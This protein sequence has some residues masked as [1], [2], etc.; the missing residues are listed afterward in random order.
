VLLHN[1]E[2]LAR[3]AVAARGADHGRPGTLVTLVSHDRRVVCEVD[4]GTTVGDLVGG[5]W[6]LP[7]P[8]SAVLVGGYGGSWVPWPQAAG[9]ALNQDSLRAAGFS[10]GAGVIA[11]LPMQTCGLVE[12]ARVMSYLADSGARQCGPCLFGLPAVAEL[13]ESLADRKLSR[14]DNRRLDRYLA[15]IP[16]RGACRHPDGAIRMLTS[17][18]AT[19]ADDVEAHRHGRCLRPGTPPVLPL[20]VTAGGR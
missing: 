13:A 15:Q 4:T 1:A 20:P 7:G 14:G 9:L 2:T 6:P 11:P 10:L 12:A 17:A 5:L 18:L 8:P 3:V 19:F 16:G